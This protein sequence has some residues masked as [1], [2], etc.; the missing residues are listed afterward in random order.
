MTKLNHWA[1]WDIT[2]EMLPWVLIFSQKYWCCHDLINCYI[3]TFKKVEFYYW[4]FMI[5]ENGYTLKLLYEGFIRLWIFS[6]MDIHDYFITL[7]LKLR[8][9]AM[10]CI[11]LQWIDISKG[12]RDKSRDLSCTTGYVFLLWIEG[13]KCFSKVVVMI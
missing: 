10:N 4:N 7:L 3:L 8:I 5:F 11:L 2:F 6:N 9:Y 12:F 1:Y 13:I